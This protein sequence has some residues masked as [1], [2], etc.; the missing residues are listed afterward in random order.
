MLTT[1]IESRRRSTRN[2]GSTATSVIAHVAIITLVA[3]VTAHASDETPAIEAPRHGVIYIPVKPVPPV[4]RAATSPRKRADATVRIPDRPVVSIE[5]STVIPTTI[6]PVDLSRLP[7]N[8]A[9]F[10]IA[11]HTTSNGMGEAAA[12]SSA[13]DGTFTARQ[14]DKET[15]PL[16]GN[17][18][19]RY[20]SLLQS[21]GVGGEVLAQFVV[22]TSGRVDMS[23]FTAIEATNALFVQAVRRALAGW[24]FHPAEVGG[25]KVKQLVQMPLSFEVR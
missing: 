25:H 10:V 22:D 13:Q 6:P 7:T 21:A 4:D 20:P 8:G 18:K 15:T 19:P 5:V 24:S 2:T 1:L 23:T 11:P 16:P 14:V 9:D 17:P 12:S 3:A